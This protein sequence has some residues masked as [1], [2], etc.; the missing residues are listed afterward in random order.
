MINAGRSES[1]GMGAFVR[2]RPLAVF[3]VLAGIVIIGYGSYVYLQLTNPGMFASQPPRPAPNA[4]IA[5]PPA[6]V[7]AA[8][9][10]NGSQPAPPPL[11]SLALPE[12]EQPAS[13]AAGNSKAAAAPAGPASAIANAASAASA[14]SAA[15]IA[16][17]AATK[18]PAATAAAAPAAPSSSA[19][20][21]A[22]NPPLPQAAAVAAPEAPRDTIKITAGTTTPVI[23]PLLTEAYVALNTGNYETAQRLYNQLL[24][25]DSGNVD[26]WLGLAAIATQQGNGDQA[27]RHFIK[28]LELD[29]RNAPA[30]AGLI[31]ILGRADPQSS[32]TRVKQ[33][34]AREPS[35]AYL[36]FALAI[37]YVDQRRWPDAQQ[38]FFQAYQ[39]QPDNPDYAF[40]LAVALEH[41]GQPKAA[42]DYYRRALQL[43][44]ARGR[45]NFS[46]VTAEDRIGK[47]EKV[48]R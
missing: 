39:L 15:T 23:N 40:N 24:R 25:S 28:V 33:L 21:A 26:A 43:A 8:A 30:Q 45:A 34:I 16:A 42:L 11:S 27:T 38:A 37:T 13:A 9:A 4:K 35:A 44:T 7:Q 19:A 2:Q 47:L 31:G 29:P 6:P 22:A 10:T 48:V 20:N 46:T 32:E 36:H 5:P 14:V 12:A 18:S 17:V 1:G 3:G 41:L